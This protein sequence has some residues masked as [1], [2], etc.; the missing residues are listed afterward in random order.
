MILLGTQNPGKVAELR[1]ILG[2]AFPL[3]GLGDLPSDPPEVV[4]DGATYRENVLK[5]A[6]AYHLHSGL[7]V[8]ADDSGLEVDLLGDRPG[9]D[10][11]YYGGKELSWPE[12]WSYLHAELAPFPEDQWTARFRCV[13]CFFDGDDPVFFEGVASGRILK[14]PRGEKGFG[15]DP[16]VFSDALG[17][18]FAEAAPEEKNRVSHRAQALLQLKNWFEGGMGKR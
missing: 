12:R 18:S 1:S 7:A 16:V 11:A 9:V 14:N 5:K 17:M 15:Y 2:K 3:I 13:I 4:E 6:K 8:I 10:S